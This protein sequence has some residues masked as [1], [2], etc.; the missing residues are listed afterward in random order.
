MENI[1]EYR[2]YKYMTLR[3]FAGHVCG[4]VEIPQGHYLYGKSYIDPIYELAKFN[5]QVLEGGVG[6]L[7]SIPMFLFATRKDNEEPMSADI[8]FDVHGGITYSGK[9]TNNESPSQCFDWAI[10]FDTAHFNDDET[11]QTHEYCESECKR[12]IDQLVIF[13]EG[14]KS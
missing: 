12:L 9:L 13:D 1:K 8:L 11:T 2:N 14:L 10:G 5:E 7:G 3:M 6:K 4:Y